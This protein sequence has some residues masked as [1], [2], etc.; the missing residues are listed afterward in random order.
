MSTPVLHLASSS[1]RRR[2]LL[3][4][5]GVEFSYD[6]VAI[7]E[8]VSAGEAAADMVLRLATAKARTAFESG[9]FRVPV[10]GAD[11]VVTLDARIFGKPGSKEEALQMLASLSGRAHEVLSGVALIANGEVETAISRTEVQFREIHP[12]EAEAYWQ[13]GEPADKAG[14]YAVQGLGGIFVSGISGSYTGVVGLP[15][16]ETARLLRRAGIELPGTPAHR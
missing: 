5:L 13:S 7:D 4:G 3:A 14:A 1:P 12:D 16:F 10:L 6:G 2:E 11:T 8:S 9:A 15:V